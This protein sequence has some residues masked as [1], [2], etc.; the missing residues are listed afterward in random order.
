MKLRNVTTVFKLLINYL[1]TKVY[2]L[3]QMHILFYKEE[4]VNFSQLI[5]IILRF[6]II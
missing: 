2:S 6:L 3:K 1:L 5:I 4:K